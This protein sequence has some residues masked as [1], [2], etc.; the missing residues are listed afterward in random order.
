[1]TRAALA[2]AT[3]WV[4]PTEH[5]ANSLPMEFRDHRLHIIHEGINTQLAK[6]TWMLI[7]YCAISRL[8]VC[9]NHT[10]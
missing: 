1:M 10:R 6:L 7:L 2:D 8:I 3:A 9:N 5:Q 4:M